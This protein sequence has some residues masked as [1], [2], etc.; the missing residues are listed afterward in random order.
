MVDK[1]GLSL[2]HATSNYR[3]AL[4]SLRCARA[5]VETHI[6]IPLP[7]ATIEYIICAETEIR[8]TANYHLL[9]MEIF[10]AMAAVA[11]PSDRIT[12]IL[13]QQ[14]VALAAEM[15]PRGGRF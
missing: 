12:I 5:I 14:A 3:T 6:G 8:R 1:A 9:A 13:Q 7:P 2:A 11:K 10:N 15:L 4:A